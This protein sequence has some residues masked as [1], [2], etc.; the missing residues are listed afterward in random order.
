MRNLLLALCLM[1]LTRPI[2]GATS[3]NPAP[4]QFDQE[5]A[6]SF[7]QS[8]GLPDAPI[9]LLD[10]TEGS[11]IRAFASGRWHEL[12]AGR[13]NEIRALR[14]GSTEFIVPDHGGKTITVPLPWREVIQI[15]RHADS[16][17]LATTTDLF[18]VVDGKFASLGWPSRY[19]INQIAVSPE[20]ALTVASNDGLF[21]QHANGWTPIAALDATGRAWGVKDVLGVGYDSKGQ[22]WFGTKAGAACLTGE[23]WSM[24]EGKDGVPW[25]DFT[26]ITAGP[27]GELWFG[28]HLGAI[29]FDD[30][31]WH[32]RQG[33]RWLPHD[34]VTQVLV[35]SAG[36]AWFATP[37]GVGQIRRD[38]MT[39]AEKAE[40]YEAEI[41]KYIKR[42]PLGYI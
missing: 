14:P 9:Q 22:L 39:L 37:A 2:P 12:N 16:V 27:K 41:E 42:T 24:Y 26:G 4:Q 5:V 40:R 33:P 28:T 30:H 25:T 35:D 10:Q 3:F 21:R 31:G 19:R 38:P 8:N 34:D 6:Q 7:T 20:G 1:A 17:F 23:S 29:R 11:S 36:T 15:C 18:S 13:W 32:Y